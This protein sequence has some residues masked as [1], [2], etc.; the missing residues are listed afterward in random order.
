MLLYDVLDAAGIVLDPDINEDFV[1]RIVVLRGR[2]GYTAVIAGGE[3]E[4][5]FMNGAGAAT[6]P[7][8]GLATAP[9]RALRQR[10]RP[11]REGPGQHRAAQGLIL[12]RAGIARWGCRKGRRPG[13]ACRRCR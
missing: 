9:R 13:L 11:L 10:H 5:R 2:D 8:D 7:E 3:I 6:A 1:R 4:P 12:R